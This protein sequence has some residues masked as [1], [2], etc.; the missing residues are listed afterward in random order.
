MLN[1]TIQKVGKQM[2]AKVKHYLKEV[3]F[4]I[5]TMTVIAN[6]MSYYKSRDLNHTDFD[7][8]ESK[9]IDNSI[10]KP[11]NGVKVIHFWAT[12]CPTCKLEAANIEY[13]SKYYDVITIAVNSGSDYEIAN[14]LKE[15]N[16]NFKVINDK[17]SELSK[18][19][20][21]TAFPTTL[22]YNKDNKVVFSDVGYTSTLGL[23]VRAWIASL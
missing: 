18:L 2:R 23:F 14:Y 9:L 8:K 21:I 20:N 19:Y 6:L 5:I 11:N 17:D 4:F 12:W 13:L 22:I 1:I 16:L 15:H 10:Y 3:I 7:I